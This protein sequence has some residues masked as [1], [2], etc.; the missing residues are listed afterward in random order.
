MRGAG[1]GYYIGYRDRRRRQRRS[2][3]QM[4]ISD[5]MPSAHQEVA[6]WRHLCLRNWQEGP[7]GDTD[8]SMRCYM[9]VTG[10]D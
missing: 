6:G 3:A 5:Q 1:M 10:N 8:I 2:P 4:G 7:R 9:L